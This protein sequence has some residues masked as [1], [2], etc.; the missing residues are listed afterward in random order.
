MND[1]GL[2]SSSD[3]SA[4][5]AIESN[6]FLRKDVPLVIDTLVVNTID[7][8]GGLLTTTGVGSNTLTL[9]GVDVSGGTLD[10]LTAIAPLVITG[11][12]TDEIISL[13]DSGVTAG[14]YTVTGITVNSKGL[15]TSAAS[16]V[17]PANDDWSNFPAQTNVNMNSFALTNLQTPVNPQDGS[18]KGYVDSL[19]INNVKLT[20]AQTITGV[21]TFNALP[22][23]AVVP[24]TPTQ[25]ITKSYADGLDI[26][27]VKL[28]GDQTIAGIKT[29]NSLP[30]STVVPSTPTQLITKSYADGL[31]IN[32]VKLTGDQTIAGVKT[33]NAPPLSAVI[34]TLPTQLVNKAYVDGAL[35][36]ADPLSVVLTTGNS[37]G[38]SQIN[39]NS[40]KI[41]NLLNPTNAQDA[42][43]KNYVDNLPAPA[44][45]SL[46]EVLTVD[47]TASSD[48]EMAGFDIKDV[49]DI[50]MSG[51][52]PTITATNILGNLTITSAATM[53]MG[54]AGQMTLASGGILSL[55]GATYTTIENLR[56]D[57][58][59]ITKESGADIIINNV[60]TIGNVTTLALSA[61]TIT[62]PL[63]TGVTNA[64]NMLTFSTGSKE[65]N[66]QPVPVIPAAQSLSN[67]LSIGNTSGANDIV[68][69]AGQNIDVTA[70]EI[71][72]GTLNVNSIEPL[73]PLISTD[74]GIIGN[75]VFPGAISL[76]NNASG[77]GIGLS[78][79]S[80]PAGTTSDILG[81]NPLTYE[82]TYQAAPVTPATP[83]LA[84]VLTAGNTTD[85]LNIHIGT[86]LISTAEESPQFINMGNPWMQIE[87]EAGDVRIIATENVAVQNFLFTE[88]LLKSAPITGSNKLIQMD[89]ADPAIVLRGLDV[90]N[91][92]EESLILTNNQF[93]MTGSD[94]E[95]NI[96][97]N[98]YTETSEES[99]E[100][101]LQQSNTTSIIQTTNISFNVSPNL[102]ANYGVSGFNISNAAGSIIANNQDIS[103]FT[104]GVAGVS[105]QFTP[106]YLLLRN[107][108]I[109]V[110][111]SGNVLTINN[112]GGATF[113][114]YSTNLPASSTLNILFTTL[115]R[116]NGR[117]QI[118][119]NGATGAF[120]SNSLANSIITNRTDYTAP[121]SV[122]AGAIA[123]M[124]ILYDLNVN[125]ISVQVFN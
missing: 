79:N 3:V 11:T 6:F 69:N 67:V 29:F 10:T 72:T 58:N 52:I 93:R 45:P 63:I 125:F 113:N 95:R 37:A 75:L 32:N 97:M 120:I 117:Y 99:L 124:T 115:F 8:N 108:V 24:T 19:D 96:T 40:N 26:N 60:G 23:S 64:T 61:P 14:T 90:S 92:Q 116:I 88:G 34:P 78:I 50:T 103:F 81:Y 100:I 62:A 42:V 5:G 46:G 20:G 82:I 33:F 39:M 107:S 21:K 91:E 70:G 98:L 31:D 109:P 122:P 104:T 112:V 13:A 65:I 55:G 12:T 85:G 51:L 25:L 86:G 74:I 87:N 101:R 84:Q 9:N 121:I 106:N 41:V 114:W 15:I 66:F 43:T 30:L 71:F 18:T 38:A 35:P 22:L 1:N 57:N 53:N 56:I 83:T 47:N 7:L 105:S 44:V 68:M 27:N 76:K 59:V 110:V 49:N 123:I 54:T 102:S 28:T 16:G 36:G 119:F 118:R 77:A 4:T 80:I 2:I 89:P 73:D 111:T 94:G 48:I 17:I